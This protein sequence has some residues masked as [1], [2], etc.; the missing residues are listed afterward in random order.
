VNDRDA[1]MAAVVDRPEDDTPRLVLADWYDDHQEHDRAAFIRR[2]VNEGY[3]CSFV[4]GHDSLGWWAGTHEWGER[5]TFTIRRG[6]ID[7]VECEAATWLR[8]AD[9][10]TAAHPVRRV[11]LTTLDVGLLLGGSLLRQKV[12]GVNEWQC[13]RWPSITF[14]FPPPARTHQYSHWADAID[15]HAHRL[16]TALAVPAELL[17]DAATGYAEVMAA[18]L[19]AASRMG[20][21][22][23]AAG[24]ALRPAM[25]AI[26]AAL[27]ET[28]DVCD[29]CGAAEPS[30]YFGGTRAEG[31]F[32]GECL[33]TARMEE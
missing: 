5:T 11:T 26:A 12:G 14:T 25:E 29:R 10:I 20:E 23:A 1:L 7:E 21:S 2:G 22:M 32:C 9:A 13:D 27:P 24:A 17:R 4:G 8:L 16:T 18:L 31:W 28:P 15:L 33:S 3:E 30:D 6:M 19:P